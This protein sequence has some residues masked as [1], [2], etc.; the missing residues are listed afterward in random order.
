MVCTSIII[1]NNNQIFYSKL[2]GL[3]LPLA[4]TDQRKHFENSHG[5]TPQQAEEI[6]R[7][8]TRLL[9]WRK[10]KGFTEVPGQCGYCLKVFKCHRPLG[11]LL[12]HQK[13]CK[14]KM[15]TIDLSSESTQET[16]STLED[17]TEDSGPVL[18]SLVETRKTAELQLEIKMLTKQ[19]EQLKESKVNKLLIKSKSRVTKLESK[20]RLLKTEKKKLYDKYIQLLESLVAKQTST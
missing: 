3:D 20:V 6:H 14:S 16:T 5:V 8:P 13:V 18:D 4:K 7:C 10:M 1:Q 17:I 15:V 19:K 2:C 11:V 12:K 9:N